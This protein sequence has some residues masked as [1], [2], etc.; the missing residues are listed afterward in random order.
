MGNGNMNG[1]KKG[2]NSSANPGKEIM[3]GGQ[4]NGPSGLNAKDYAQ[5][6]EYMVLNG[7]SSKE[8]L[9]TAGNGV[10]AGSKKAKLIKIEQISKIVKKVKLY[11]LMHEIGL[12][13]FLNSC[14]L[15]SKPK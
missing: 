3:F 6:K 2:G 11:I 12:E 8:Y 1:R 15:Y 4:A 5:G 9:S 10:A 7:N 13:D 14:I